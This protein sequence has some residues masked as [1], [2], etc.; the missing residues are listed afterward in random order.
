MRV[1]FDGARA[2]KS[3]LPHILSRRKGCSTLGCF[4][5]AHVQQPTRVGSSIRRLA[6]GAMGATDDSSS[7]RPYTFVEMQPGQQLD[8]DAIYGGAVI[9]CR[10]LRPMLQLCEIGASSGFPPAEAARS[11]RCHLQ[12]HWAAQV[13]R[14]RRRGHRTAILQLLLLPMHRLQTHVIAQRWLL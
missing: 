9:V 4:H 11:S 2:T 8:R 13:Q 1:T 10:R 7:C 14:H 12:I 3:R 6:T 5:M